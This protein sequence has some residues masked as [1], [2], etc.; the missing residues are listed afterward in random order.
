MIIHIYSLI[1]ILLPH[2]PVLIER[3]VDLCFSLEYVLETQKTR[4]SWRNQ[5]GVHLLILRADSPTGVLIVIR[6]VVSA[7]FTTKQTSVEMS[8][9]NFSFTFLSS[10]GCLNCSFLSTHWM[11]CG[12]PE[13]EAI[14]HRR[15]G[16]RAFSSKNKNINSSFNGDIKNKL[17]C[18]LRLEEG[19]RKG[20]KHRKRRSKKLFLWSLWE[21]K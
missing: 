2:I 3:I 18:V 1:Y 6:R 10:Q 11:F 15:E 5:F 19:R 13:F 14:F 4:P 20:L 8:I 7:F 16:G 12:R 17:K 9:V 21:N